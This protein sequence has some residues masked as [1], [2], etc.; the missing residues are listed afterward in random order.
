MDCVNRLPNQ[1]SVK[2]GIEPP[3][4]EQQREGGRA[5]ESDQKTDPAAPEIAEPGQEQFA[6]AY[7][8]TP[9]R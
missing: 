1:A 6:E 2:S 9:R 7:A 5:R 3:N 4:A 8:N